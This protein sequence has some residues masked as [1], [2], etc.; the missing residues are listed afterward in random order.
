[1]KRRSFI[2]T[3]AMVSSTALLSKPS[4]VFN[5]LNEAYARGD[6]S[7]KPIILSTWDFKLPVNETAART[8]NEGGTLV[9]AVE[10]AI[11]LVEEDP[12]ITSVGRGG[13][14]DRD[15]HLT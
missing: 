1:M 3:A 11:R 2:K 7:T 15:G 8:L 4:L 13:Y 10:K 6:S 12:T 5:D 9:D 14:P